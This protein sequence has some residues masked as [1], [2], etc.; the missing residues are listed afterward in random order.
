MTRSMFGRRTISF[1]L[2]LPLVAMAG[3]A[4][5]G[6]G[7]DT[8]PPSTRGTHTVMGRGLF[9]GGIMVLVDAH[10]T[11][12]RADGAME[13]SQ[14][15]EGGGGALRVISV[16][17]CVG[18]FRDGTE[19]VVAGPVSQVYGDIR[20][21]FDTQDWWV[22]EIREGGEEGDLIRANR[23]PRIRA[24]ERCHGGP[25]SIPNLRSVDG[26]ISIH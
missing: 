15:H 23:Q 17:S 22:L 18:I 21:L 24:L 20:N 26:D 5:M 10:L 1:F 14:V 13:Y 9:T 25:T 7:I 6:S 12:G 16:V 11:D 19:A 2:A 3:C 4:S 8:S